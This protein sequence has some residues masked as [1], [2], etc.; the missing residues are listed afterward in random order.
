MAG[1][2]A[3]LQFPQAPHQSNLKYYQAV[4]QVAHQAVTV[5]TASAGKVAITA[6]EPCKNQYMDLQMAQYTQCVLLAH[7]IVAAAVHVIK[8]V[9]MDAPVLLMALA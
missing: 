9:V 5:I 8:I 2:V 1:N 7:Q 6:K 4:A 3:L